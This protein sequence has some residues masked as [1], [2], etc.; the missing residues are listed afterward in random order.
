MGLGFGG[1][2]SYFYQRYRR[3]YP[4]TVLDSV[5]SAFD[6]SDDDLVLDL[7]CGTGQ[8][9]LPLADRVDAVVG[10]DPEPDMLARARALANERGIR[11]VSWM[12][13]ADADV[14]A[15]D[16]LLGGRLL[17]AV[18]IGQALH[19]MDHDAL[20]QALLPLLRAG[21]GVAVLANGTPLWLQE[22]PWSE[23][24]RRHLEGWLGTTATRTCGT[25]DDSRQRYGDSLVAAGFAVQE[26]S[27]QY[28]DELDVEQIV[29]GVYSAL[30][31]DRLPTAEQRPRF[32][33]QVRIAVE[34]YRPYVE[35]VRV[36]ALLGR[37][38]E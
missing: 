2:V 3:G 8:L 14:P 20:F 35:H 21:G 6:L 12:L 4:A 22:T 29:G 32:A 36:T 10:M 1:E 17:G 27:E 26:T 19:W 11:N 33:E 25:D 31:V 28:T 18:T 7:G 5:I 37:V 9:S 13:G 15:L 38:A 34:P 23:A 16:R 24:L 30:P